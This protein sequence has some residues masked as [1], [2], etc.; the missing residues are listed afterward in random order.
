MSLPWLRENWLQLVSEHGSGKLSHAHCVP[1]QPDLGAEAFIREWLKLLLCTQPQRKACGVC[2][3]CLLH[4]AGNHPDYYEVGSIDGKGISVD[5]IRELTGKLQQTPNQA[6]V[7]V[8]WLRDAERMSVT[9]A[10]ALLKT[11]EEPTQATYFVVS[12]ERTSRL[13]PTL[14]SR[15]QLHRFNVPSEQ[16]VEQWLAQQLKRVLS[17]KE[18]E[19][20]K[21]YHQRPL[22]LLGWLQ[23]D[24]APVD[25]LQQLSAALLGDATWPAVD[26][27]SCQGW[28]SATEQLLGELVRVQQNLGS[29]HLQLAGEQLR[30]QRWL[31][32]K[33]YKVTDLNH[34][35]KSCYGMRRKLAEQSGLNGPLLL[36]EIWMR[37]H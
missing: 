36:Q 34:W 6:G 1:W 24:N 11:L 33:N 16:Q 32:E 13:L 15:M 21:R 26:K 8:V 12:P 25:Q 10:N 31:T 30:L 5:Q 29:D 9:A 23:S 27:A 7:K 35:L 19:L 2:K 14:R 37:L 18:H 22:A 3:G 4:K 28:L 17:A 20:C